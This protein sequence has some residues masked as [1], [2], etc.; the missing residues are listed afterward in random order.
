VSV[1]VD[2]LFH[3]YPRPS[4]RHSEACHMTADSLEE[5]HAFARSIGLKRGWF[6]PGRHAHYDLTRSRRAFAVKAGAL[7]IGAREMQR[8]AR[9]LRTGTSAG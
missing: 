9:L 4:W 1:Y 3:T 2:Q 6:Q 7:E 8:R 5:L